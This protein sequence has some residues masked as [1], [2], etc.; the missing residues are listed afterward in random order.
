MRGRNPKPAELRAIEGGAG[1]GGRDLSHRPK[2]S[3]PKYAPLTDHPPEWLPR[4]AKAEWR[5]LIAEFDR[6][7][8]LVQ[9]PDRATFIAWCQEWDRYVQASRDVNERGA[10]LLVEAGESLDGRKFYVQP[11]KNPN[12]QIARDCLEKLIALS[13]RYGLTPGDRVRLNIGKGQGHEEGGISGLL[14]GGGQK[15]G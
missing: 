1:K 8:G 10:V 13:S 6:I 2:K 5:R 14:T 15:S 9:R 12:V 7:P 4:E 11:K 3:A